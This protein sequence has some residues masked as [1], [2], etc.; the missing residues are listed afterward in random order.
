MENEDR[1]EKKHEIES[2]KN[3]IEVLIAKICLVTFGR[4]ELQ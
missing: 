2:I 4:I 1:E 3:Y